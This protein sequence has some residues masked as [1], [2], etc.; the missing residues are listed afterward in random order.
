MKFFIKFK[1]DLL[2]RFIE[3]RQNILLEGKCSKEELPS[4][5]DQLKKVQGV[6]EF[7]RQEVMSYEVRAAFRNCLFCFSTITIFIQGKEKEMR[8]AFGRE[9]SKMI[10]WTLD[11]SNP[12]LP[13]LNPNL[14]G[15]D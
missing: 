11:K 3:E 13:S 2:T 9:L 7:L 4:L 12:C 5:Q 6:N 8:Y 1:E 14:A 10:V 15:S